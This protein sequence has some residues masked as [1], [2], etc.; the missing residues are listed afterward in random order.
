VSEG[1]SEVVYL[2]HFKALLLLALAAAN[3]LR[4]G[5]CV[6]HLHIGHGR[7]V[8]VGGVF[9]EGYRVAVVREVWA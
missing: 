8:C 7:V 9:V 1:G 5:R 6:G 4:L 3:L 2:L